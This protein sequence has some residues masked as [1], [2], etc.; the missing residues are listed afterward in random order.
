MALSL[1]LYAAAALAVLL[2][3]ARF[4]RHPAAIRAEIDES[5]HGSS[6]SEPRITAERFHELVLELLPELGLAIEHTELLSRAG[7]MRIKASSVGALRDTTYVVYAEWRSSPAHRIEPDVLLE[8][9]EDVAHGSLPA[10]GVL[11]SPCHIDRAATAGLDHELELI[12]GL[13]F[14][15][16]VYDHL[17]QHGDEVARYQLT[18]TKATS[19]GRPSRLEDTIP[20]GPAPSSLRELRAGHVS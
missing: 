3:I 20:Q 19:G 5:L 2:A 17:P 11:V 14:E 10:V 13:G 16:L 12:D 1:F 4:A 9:N 7:A 15:E 18:G 6:P 8:L